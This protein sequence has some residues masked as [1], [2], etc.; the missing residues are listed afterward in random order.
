M[1]EIHGAPPHIHVLAALRL[2]LM[3]LLFFLEFAINVAVH[4]NKVIIVGC[5]AMKINRYKPTHTT[6]TDFRQ[7]TTFQ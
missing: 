7:H 4:I 1:L 6:L 2:Q 5:I 3:H